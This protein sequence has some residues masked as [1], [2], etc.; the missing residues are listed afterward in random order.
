MDYIAIGWLFN[1][2]VTGGS[3]FE[4]RVL[5]ALHM[6]G[7]LGL[8]DILT[9]YQHISQFTVLPEHLA[10]KQDLIQQIG[11][12]APG[13]FMS[14]FDNFIW[15][16]SSLSNNQMEDMLLRV[17]LISFISGTPHNQ[18][19]FL[20]M[21]CLNNFKP[22]RYMNGN[23]PRIEGFPG[24]PFFF[25]FYAALTCNL[26]FLG[27]TAE[28]RLLTELLKN[29]NSNIPWLKHL[30]YAGLLVGGGMKKVSTTAGYTI[31]KNVMNGRTVIYIVDDIT[32][33]RRRITA[34]EYQLYQQMRANAGGLLGAG[35]A[36]INTPTG[37]NVIGVNYSTNNAM[38]TLAAIEQE[39]GITRGEAVYRLATD[40][41]EGRQEV[42]DF[43]YT[44]Q[45][46]VRWDFKE[47]LEGTF[48]SL[49]DQ[50][51]IGDSSINKNTNLQRIPLGILEQ[52]I[53]YHGRR[54]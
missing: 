32:G 10:N 20:H 36:L 24:G 9:L 19:Q 48:H 22:Q 12:D 18:W 49:Y 17:Q 33:H 7:R 16:N 6:D 41:A 50:G 53:D 34:A 52:I 42:F 45:R 1:R 51:E 40:G 5:L 31:L 2:L 30:I 39:L 38:I 28:G 37:V 27:R 13:Q 15:G 29:N 46:G 11:I 44:G 26:T 25:S 4:Y 21:A 54:Q 43:T 35:G 3:D 47:E 8:G 14:E 23:L